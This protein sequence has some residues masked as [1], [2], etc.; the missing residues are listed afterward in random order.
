MRSPPHYSPLLSN[1][2]HAQTRLHTVDPARLLL[3]VPLLAAAIGLGIL[4]TLHVAALPYV[5]LLVFVMAYSSVALFGPRPAQ[6]TLLMYAAQ[7]YAGSLLLTWITALYVLPGHPASAMVSLAVLLHLTTVYVFLFV[8]QSPR[9]ATR[10][11]A[12][13][14]TALVVTA[15]PHAG[16]TLGQTGVLDGVTL[17]VTLLVSHGALITVLRSFG[18]FR[19]RAAHAEGRAQAL[20]ELA[21]R[22]PL[23]GLPNRRALERDLEL[24]VTGTGAGWLAVVDVDGLKE[25]NDRL[26]HAAGD[27]LL[28]RFAEGFAQGAEP[29]GQVYRISGDEFALLLPGGG[30]SAGAVMDAVTL[31]VRATYPGAAASVGAARWRAGETADAWLARA[32]QTM[33]RHKRRGGR[34]SQ[35]G[36]SSRAARRR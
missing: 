8:Q 34:D 5:G 26:G 32:D 17:P 18:T 2:Q 11:A 33:Y 31:D 25:V 23:T 3:W 14:L 36:T 9:T 4:V 6:T 16:Q 28:R 29:G 13:T 7:V 10:W 24:A 19:D 12:G 20:H 27:D 15:L 21:H 30:P 35:Q 22:D 1:P